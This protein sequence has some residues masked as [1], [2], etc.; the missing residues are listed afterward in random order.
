MKKIEKIISDSESNCFACSGS[1]PK[2]LQM[3]FY[4]DN[5]EVV[6]FWEPEKYFDGWAG[7]LHGGIM[8]TLLDEVGEWVVYSKLETA[9]VTTSLN[10]KYKKPV[11]TTEGKI[12]IRGKLKKQLRNIAFVESWILDA[13][14]NKCVVGE[15]S[16]YTYPKEKAIKE[17]NINL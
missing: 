4:E 11:N 1:N 10:V 15:A 12:E 7:M 2:G 5:D 8:A 6:C 9:G 14:Q 16:Y 17:L 3:E 13:N